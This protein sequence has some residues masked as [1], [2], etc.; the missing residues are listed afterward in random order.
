MR[1]L[2]LLAGLV[3]M[4]SLVA[5]QTPQTDSKTSAKPK[6]SSPARNQPSSALDRARAAQSDDDV[7]ART[8]LRRIVEDLPEEPDEDREASP[9]L[10]F[11][12]KLF[13]THDPNGFQKAWKAGA[14][15]L[16]TARTI[17]Q[18]NPVMVMVAVSGCARGKDGKCSI[19][20][21]SRTAG[22]DG[23]FDQ[24]KT[25]PP[26]KPAP[27]QGKSEL[28][29]ASFGLR[30]GPGDLPGR[31]TIEV[32]VTDTVAKASRTLTGTVNKPAAAEE[33]R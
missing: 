12:A 27:I 1:R 23:L 25:S 5:A 11:A 2:I 29:P 9:R 20:F 14:D 15:S 26:W 21:A 22:P 16:P 6:S 30:L 33:G 7:S 4:S 19:E 10:A 31:Y 8:P 28:A 18:A 17:G 13:L 3:T 24:P 32:K